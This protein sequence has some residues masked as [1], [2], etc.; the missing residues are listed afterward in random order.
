LLNSLKIHFIHF[1]KWQIWKCEEILDSE[2][3]YLCDA[4]KMNFNVNLSVC[5]YLLSNINQ[6]LLS[7]SLYFIRFLKLSINMTG[8]YYINSLRLHTGM[9]LLIHLLFYHFIFEDKTKI[10]IT[11]SSL[12]RRDSLYTFADEDDP[13]VVKVVQCSPHRSCYK[14]KPNQDGLKEAIV[15]EF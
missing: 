7:D 2:H 4:E 13:T 3:N 10:L 5:Q 14:K 8:W 15:V 9:S 6:W 11:I 1:S 12:C